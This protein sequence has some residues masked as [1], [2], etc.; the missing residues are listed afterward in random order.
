VRALIANTTNRHEAAPS[1]TAL[2]AAGC[3]VGRENGAGR[4]GRA[5]VTWGSLRRFVKGPAGAAPL[6]AEAPWSRRPAFRCEPR[7]PLSWI[8]QDMDRLRGAAVGQWPEEWAN[9]HE[10]YMVFSDFANPFI[11]RCF[12][13]DHGEPARGDARCD[14][15]SWRG[16]PSYRRWHATAPDRRLHQPPALSTP[17]GTADA[18]GCAARRAVGPQRQRL[19]RTAGPA[20]LKA[21]RQAAP[22]TQ[23][24]LPLWPWTQGVSRPETL[25]E[26]SGSDLSRSAWRSGSGWRAWGRPC[27]RCASSA[28][29]QRSP[30]VCSCRHGRQPLPRDGPP[31]APPR[32]P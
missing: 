9:R 21:Q 13:P 27:R 29:P 24:T 1:R 18:T 8:F 7:D 6:R 20:R 3:P 11:M 28:A 2:T 12:R 23:Q 17:E 19:S 16:R 15:A 22:A 4:P 10:T 30:A 5:V 25:R 14:A 31:A 26:A 32:S